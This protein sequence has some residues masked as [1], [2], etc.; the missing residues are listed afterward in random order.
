MSPLQEN[1][2]IRQVSPV[3]LLLSAMSIVLPEK[4]DK[5]KHTIDFHV[6]IVK[7]IDTILRGREKKTILEELVSAQ[8]P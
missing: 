5:I 3:D 6:D 7:K 4:L 2:K 1:K 8:Q